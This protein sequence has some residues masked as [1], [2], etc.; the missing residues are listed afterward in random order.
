MLNEESIRVAM[1]SAGIGVD[2]ESI[3]VGGKFQDYGLDS[4]DVFNLLL[5]VQEQTGREIPDN[6]VPKLDSIAAIL[7]YFK[8]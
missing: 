1:K 7:D 5:E 4:L 3:P 6:D 2:I 8:A